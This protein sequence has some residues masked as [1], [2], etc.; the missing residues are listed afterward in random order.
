MV[1][2]FREYLKQLAEVIT[3][4]EKLF[5]APSLALRYLKGDTLDQC[6]LEKLKEVTA[7]WR[8]RLTGIS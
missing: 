2:L 5:R 8:E 3:R 1:F 7:I 4:W 6:E